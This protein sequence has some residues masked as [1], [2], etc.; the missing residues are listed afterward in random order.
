MHVFGHLISSGCAAACLEKGTPRY[1]VA[2][3]MPHRYWI[4]GKVDDLDGDGNEIVE[5]LD[6]N[7]F[8]SSEGCGRVE[9]GTVNFLD[10][11]SLTRDFC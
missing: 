1:S 2:Q 3:P 7:E 4:N 8:M 5:T 11:V 10:D 6:F 9:Y